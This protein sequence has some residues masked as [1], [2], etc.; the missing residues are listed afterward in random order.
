ME[1]CSEYTLSLSFSPLLSRSLSLSLWLMLIIIAQFRQHCTSH[2]SNLAGVSVTEYTTANSPRS[3]FTRRREWLAAVRALEQ[4][5]ISNA[6]QGFP[7]W[8][9]A[10]NQVTGLNSYSWVLIIFTQQLNNECGLLCSLMTVWAV[11]EIHMNV[12]VW[13]TCAAD[14]METTWDGMTGAFNMLKIT[15]KHVEHIECHLEGRYLFT[16]LEEMSCYFQPFN[17]THGVFQEWFN[18][19]LSS[20]ILFCVT[21]S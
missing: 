3:E 15:S 9:L 18:F 16:F 20:H 2:I 19:F 8:S 10:E 5:F 1:C 14:G 17:N 7:F 11:G 4:G 12:D 6:K 13:L 21:M